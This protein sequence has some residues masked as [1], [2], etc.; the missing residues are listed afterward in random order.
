[1]VEKKNMGCKEVSSIVHGSVHYAEAYMANMA[2]RNGVKMKIAFIVFAPTL[3]AEFL[4]V[5]LAVLVGVDDRVLDGRPVKLPPVLEL[6][7]PPD[8][9]SLSAFLTN[10]PKFSQSV[11]FALMAPTPPEPHP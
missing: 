10:A 11:S 3:S 7:L 1:M 6:V 8:P 2:R 4:V 9:L 5:P